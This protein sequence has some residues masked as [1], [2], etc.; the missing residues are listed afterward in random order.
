MRRLVGATLQDQV[1]GDVI[2]YNNRTEVYTVEARRAP[3]GR[4]GSGRVR[5]VLAPRAPASRRRPPPAAAPQTPCPPPAPGA[6]WPA[7]RLEVRGLRKNYGARAWCKTCRWTCQRRGGGPAGPQRRRQDHL[8]LHDRRPGARRR[9]QHPHRRQAVEHMPIHRRSRLG[10]SYLPQEASIFRKL[11]V[12]EN[13][14]A[15]LELQQDE[16]ASRCRATRSSSA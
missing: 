8:V 10:L 2:V 3:G 12:A 5:A 6:R 15:V 13:V 14:R 16:T 1:T 4:G 9:R 7:S 11:T